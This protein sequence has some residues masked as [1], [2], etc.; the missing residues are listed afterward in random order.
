M[1]IDARHISDRENGLMDQFGIPSKKAHQQI[2]LLR[3]I[4]KKETTGFLFRRKNQCPNSPCFA[5]A[6]QLR[7]VGRPSGESNEQLPE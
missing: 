3:L 7:K 4:D 1:D 6:P 5:T 2:V